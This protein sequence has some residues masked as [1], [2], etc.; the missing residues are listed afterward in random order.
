MVHIKKSDADAVFGRWLVVGAAT[1]AGPN[2]TL[3]PCYT[4]YR[5]S[6]QMAV[7]NAE[8]VELVEDL[9][10]APPTFGFAPVDYSKKD[11]KRKALLADARPEVE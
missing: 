11:R 3:Q 10:A 7:V 1:I 9:H 5:K 6:E 8:R 2:G 4:L